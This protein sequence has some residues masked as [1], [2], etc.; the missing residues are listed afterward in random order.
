MII[1][2]AR[3]PLVL[4]FKVITSLV[5]PDIKVFPV[6]LFTPVYNPPTNLSVPSVN[7]SKSVAAVSITKVKVAPKL[8]V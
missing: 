1:L 4:P 5:A 7:I 6:A 3:P 8:L 2:P